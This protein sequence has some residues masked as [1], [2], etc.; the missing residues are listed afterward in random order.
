MAGQ[1]GVTPVALK[2]AGKEEEGKVGEPFAV[3]G[4]APSR[5]ALECAFLTEGQGRVD[6]ERD[7]ESR[8]RCSAGRVLE[9]RWHGEGR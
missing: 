2:T 3:L 7:H 4:G 8:R 1:A 9:A 5:G 6:G